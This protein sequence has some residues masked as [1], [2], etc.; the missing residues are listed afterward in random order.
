MNSNQTPPLVH[1]IW[2]GDSIELAKRFHAKRRVRSVITDP[3]FGVDNQSKSA[4]T[5]HGKKMARKIEN[6]ATPEQAMDIFTK[7]MASVLP[8]M[9]DDSDIYVFTSWQVLE[10]WIKFTK[11]L[12]NPHG[13]D[14]KAIL[15][16][17]KNGPGQGDLNTWGMG[18]EFALYF[19]RGKW[20]GNGRR[21]NAV[22]HYDQI[23]AGKLIHPHEKPEPLLEGL[24]KHSTNPGDFVIDPFGGSGS[25]VRAARNCGRSAVSMEL[26]KNNYD[27]AVRKFEEA[28]SGDIFAE[29]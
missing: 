15:T 26:N 9:M 6:D 22:L 17:E 19:K 12:F 25:L 14:H 24:I 5:P 3:P 1:Q 20:T 27:L 21:R 8:G 2:H 11:E 16:W 10:V 23:P 29:D 13:F 28:G 18:V 4:V 7:V